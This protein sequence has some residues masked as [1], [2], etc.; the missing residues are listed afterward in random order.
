MNYKYQFPGI[1]SCANADPAGDGILD[2]SVGDRIV[3]DENHLDENLG[4]CGTLAWD[5]NG[6]NGIESD[7]AFDI[8]RDF[9]DVPDGSL[10]VLHDYDDWGNFIFTGLITNLD[11][12]PTPL[13]SSSSKIKQKTEIVSCMDTPPSVR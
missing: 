4:T 1:D 2:Y 12:A 11:G 10:D 7:I 9:D 13:S 5:W 3:L 8:N 6:I